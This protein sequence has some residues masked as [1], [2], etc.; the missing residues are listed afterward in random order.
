MS[1]EIQRLL[2]AA[3]HFKA[4]T[5]GAELP[6]G[7][8]EAVDA[9]QKALGE[10][11]PERDTPGARAA[12]RVAPGTKGTGEPF[13]KAARGVDGPSPGQRE[14]QSLSQQIQEAAESIAA[15]NAA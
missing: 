3:E 7:A 14:A 6:K 12:L 5:R 8:L 4:R 13:S 15:K 11:M 9:L 10:P 1:M 2:Q